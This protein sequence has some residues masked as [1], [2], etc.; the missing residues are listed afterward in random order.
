MKN[1]KINKDDILVVKYNYFLTAIQHVNNNFQ[2]SHKSLDVKKY[3]IIKVKCWY[4]ELYIAESDKELHQ[5][6]H[7]SLTEFISI[8]NIVESFTLIL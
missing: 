3:I 6:G 8:T 1:G 7:S 2:F 4:T 5:T